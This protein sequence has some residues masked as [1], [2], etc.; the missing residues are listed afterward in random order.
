MIPNSNVL[1]MHAIWMSVKNQGRHTKSN[2]LFKNTA[3][4]HNFVETDW[5]LNI[6]ITY[7]ALLKL[8]D[9]GF[10]HK[11]EP[12]SCVPQVS[13]HTHIHTCICPTASHIPR[14]DNDSI[15]HHWNTTMVND[16]GTI[17]QFDKYVRQKNFSL[18][19]VLNNYGSKHLA[20]RFV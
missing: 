8:V 5:L 4:K 14:A 20:I 16:K 6:R 18:L 17:T 1:V 7:V 11:H 12:F 15:F 10:A 2:L 9:I 13:N 19:N 3:M